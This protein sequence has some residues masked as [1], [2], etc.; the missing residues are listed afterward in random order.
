MIPTFTGAGYRVVAPDLVGFGRSDKF[1]DEDAY[2]YPMQGDYM[3]RLVRELDLAHVTFFGQD[4]GGLI[5]LRVVAAAP[6]RFVGVVVSN[7]G[8]PAAS[9]IQ[10]FF[11]YPLFNLAVWW[12]GALALEELQAEVTFPRG[13]VGGVRELGQTVPRRV[14]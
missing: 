4:R 14:H 12:E 2:S 11:A 5:G 10:S 8:L 13:S 6:E 3:L 9:G 7:T 1:M